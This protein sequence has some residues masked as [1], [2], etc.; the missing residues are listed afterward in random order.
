MCISL[1]NNYGKTIPQNV[2]ISIS[3]VEREFSKFSKYFQN[4]FFLVI[5]YS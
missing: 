4:L 3:G 1:H 2:I 5:F